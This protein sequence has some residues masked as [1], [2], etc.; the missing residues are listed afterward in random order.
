MLWVLLWKELF[1][2]LYE[3]IPGFLAGLIVTIIVSRF[4]SPPPA[5]AE[6]MESVKQVVGHPF[7]RTRN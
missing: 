5:A 3:M 6:E 1:F 4:T 7:R 2:D